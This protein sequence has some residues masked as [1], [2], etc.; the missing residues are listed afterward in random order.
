M[1]E[2][3]PVTSFLQ[4]TVWKVISFVL[5]IGT[6]S[7]LSLVAIFNTSEICRA[8]GLNFLLLMFVMI[9]EEA[10]G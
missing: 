1:N 4:S 8:I 5:Y 3:Q 7:F 6:M 9:L 10:Y 2:Y